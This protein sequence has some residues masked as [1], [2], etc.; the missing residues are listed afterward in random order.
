MKVFR[1]LVV[2]VSLSIK[3]T[4]KIHTTFL[5]KAYCL[6]IINYNKNIKHQMPNQDHKLY[7]EFINGFETSYT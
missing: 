7:K 1:I 3:L 5:I 4:Q 2:F 6:L